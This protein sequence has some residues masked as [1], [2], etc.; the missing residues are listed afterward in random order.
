MSRQKHELDAAQ[1]HLDG[2]AA[3]ARQKA[4]AREAALAAAAAVEQGKKDKKATDD[5][6]REL[7]KAA[8]TARQKSK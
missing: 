6:L 5:K 2:L 4:A 8:K 1:K 3:T 7:E